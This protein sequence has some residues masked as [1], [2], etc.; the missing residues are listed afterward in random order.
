MRISA[1]KAAN[2]SIY[3]LIL[4]TVSSASVIRHVPGIAR[5]ED[6]ERE[7]ARQALQSGQ[8]SADWFK[9][10]EE[11][12]AALDA[13]KKEAEETAEA[14]RAKDE[15]VRQW[16]QMYL[17]ILQTKLDPQDVPNDDDSLI[18][19]VSNAIDVA[20]LKFRDRLAFVEG[21]VQ[22]NSNEFEEPEL[23]YAALSW[24]ATVYWNAK[25]GKASCSDFD[26]SCRETCQFRYAAHQSEVTMGMFSSDYEVVWNKKKVKLK[27]HL[28]YG[29][30]PEPRHTIRIAFFFDENIEKVVIGYVGQHQATRKSN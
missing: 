20:A 15:E 28:G 30:S 3:D 10:Y 4:A 8:V 1:I 16:K 18:E 2:K 29:T 7:S 21:R 27:E 24:L 11:D 13:L 9:Q 23:F 5:W 6:I 12:L 25:A 17:Q 14:L 22:K 26:K 19:D